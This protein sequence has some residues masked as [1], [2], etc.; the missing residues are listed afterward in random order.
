MTIE[1]NN[2]DLHE[3]I[4]LDTETTGLGAAHQVIELA[5]LALPTL[6]QLQTVSPI[7]ANNCIRKHQSR[8][9]PS[10]DIDPRAEEIHGI[11]IDDLEDC[12]PVEEMEVPRCNY[13]IAHNAAFD[14]GM[15]GNPDCKVI[16]TIKLAKLV[17]TKEEVGRYALTHLVDTLVE[18]GKSL[19]VE[20]HSALSDCYLTLILLQKILDKFPRITSWEELWKLQEGGKAKAPARVKKRIEVMPLGKYKGELLLNV[21]VDYL[22]WM[23]KQD[24][25][26]PDLYAAI[27]DAIGKPG[28]KA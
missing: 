23:L 25:V 14:H 13:F 10:V 6:E 12:P 11:S 7:Y 9:C 26:K 16:C 8:W 2:Q 21:P 4:I 18:D 19:T 5:Y 15:L 24:W 3:A 1:R 28:S 22:Q 17:W 20:A 27:E